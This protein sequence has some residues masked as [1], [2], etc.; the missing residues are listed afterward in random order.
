MTNIVV[1]KRVGYN[2]DIR[3]NVTNKKFLD[4]YKVRKID[5]FQEKNYYSGKI[6]IYNFTA[7]EISASFI[8]DSILNDK[9]I[10]Y[11]IPRN[12]IKYI[13]KLKIYKN[14]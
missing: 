4:Q 1:A 10:N 14:N 2:D 6:F 5:K 11:L 8:R 3:K 9:N 13:N 12:I 7:F